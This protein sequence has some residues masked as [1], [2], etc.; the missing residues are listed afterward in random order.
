M[1][2]LG[3][4]HDSDKLTPEFP[5]FDN[6]GPACDNDD[7]PPEEVTPETGDNYINADISFPMGGIIAANSNPMGW[8]H[9]NPILVT[10]V[11]PQV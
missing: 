10:C 4:V 7:L 3:P 11:Y 1:N 8:A 5:H 9:T 6:D 2:R